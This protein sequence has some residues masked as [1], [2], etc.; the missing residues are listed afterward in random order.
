MLIE[1]DDDDDD[2][3]VQ[4]DHHR[5]HTHAC[6][7]VFTPAALGMDAPLYTRLLL[8]AIQKWQNSSSTSRLT[9][10]R[11]TGEAAAQKLPFLFAVHDSD[12]D[13]DSHD[14]DD[15]NND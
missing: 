13:S 12:S 11:S 2:D 8:E 1:D 14:D 4:Y 3:N 6:P 7:R 5:H 15:N 9:W 10:L